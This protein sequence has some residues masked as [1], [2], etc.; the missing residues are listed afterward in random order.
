MADQRQICGWQSTLQNP[1]FSESVTGFAKALQYAP[2]EEKDALAQD[3]KD[4]IKSMSQAL[5]SLRAERFI[6]WP[7]KE[8]QRVFYRISPK[9]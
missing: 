1:R 8:K 9:F 2:E 7:D 4:E 6:K 5:I 3:A